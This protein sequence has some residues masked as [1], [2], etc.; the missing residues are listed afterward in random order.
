MNT[1]E[2]FNHILDL[3]EN[4]DIVL[5]QEQVDIIHRYSSNLATE[6]EECNVIN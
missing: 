2:L 1:N 3:F 6:L 5:T 4:E